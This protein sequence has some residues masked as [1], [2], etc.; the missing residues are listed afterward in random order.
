M[1]VEDS[2]GLVIVLQAPKGVFVDNVVVVRVLEYAWGYPRLRQI[3]V[4]G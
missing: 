1:F 3:S 4:L 2:K